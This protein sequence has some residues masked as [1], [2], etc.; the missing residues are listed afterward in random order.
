MKNKIIINKGWS[1]EKALKRVHKRDQK[2]L[3]NVD[4]M[5]ELCLD[6]IMTD[7]AHHKQWY[8]CEILKLLDKQKYNQNKENFG[9]NIP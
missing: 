4:K 3:D 1:F 7:G 6:G 9:F 5:I 8:L 2:I